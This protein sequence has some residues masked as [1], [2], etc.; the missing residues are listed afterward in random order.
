[1]NKNHLFLAS[2]QYW[3]IWFALGLLWL[4]VH[5]PFRWRINI[6]ASFGK[7]IH[8]FPTKLKHITK[9]NIELCFPELT[10]AERATLVKKNFASL[11][12]G[13]I[14]AGMGWWLPEDKL[15]ALFKIKGLEHMDA[16]LAKGKGVILLGPHFTSLELS[17]RLWSLH[18]SFATMYRPHK[19]PFIAFLHELF[20]KNSNIQYIPRN[21]VRDFLRVL[22]N[23]M[24]IWY[25]Y[26]VDGGKTRSVFAPSLVF[27]LPL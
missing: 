24:S 26:D 5:L 22:N 15:R 12:I 21:R 4:I 1:M 10:P 11:G 8:L 27:K 18:F 25:A 20:R 17:G 14:E 19:K 2:P 3:P 13:L 7:F 6:G 23:N 9:T 16:A